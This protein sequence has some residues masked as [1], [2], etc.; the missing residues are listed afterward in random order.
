MSLKCYYHPEREAQSKCEKCGKVICVE[1]KMVYHKTVHRGTGDD[2][3]AYSERYEYCP[4]CYY[5]T[6]VKKY[7]NYPYPCIGFIII[8]IIAAISMTLFTPGIYNPMSF[9]VITLLSL[10]ILISV[11]AFFYLRFVYSPKKTAEFNAKKEEF[12]QRTKTPTITKKEEISTKFCPE[13]GTRVEPDASVCSYC[14][15]ILKE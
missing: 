2:R 6:H 14:G 7:K 13:C 4:V 12:L 8:F 10:G 9:L 5:D 1:C 3:Y 15:F 11:V